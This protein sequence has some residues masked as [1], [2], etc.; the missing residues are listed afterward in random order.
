MSDRLDHELR[1]RRIADVGAR[2]D[3]CN[4]RFR[5]HRRDET[6]ALEVGQAG[7]DVPDRAVEALRGA[8]DQDHVLACDRVD[9]AD[10]VPDDPVADDRHRVE[11]G[12]CRD[13]VLSFFSFHARDRN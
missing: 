6:V 3:P 2:P 1:R 7:A 13:R 8:A 5:F 9:L 11:G 12:R 10:A 4:R